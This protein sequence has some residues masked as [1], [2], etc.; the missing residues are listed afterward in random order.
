MATMISDQFRWD[1]I[2]AMGLNPMNLTP[3]L[4]RIAPMAAL[5]SARQTIVVGRADGVIGL[6]R[7]SGLRR[8]RVPRRCRSC[9]SP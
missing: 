6:R 8:S 2:G 3:N 7:T 4:D 1:C 5:A 9:A